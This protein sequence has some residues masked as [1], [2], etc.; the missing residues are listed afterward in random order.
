[1]D[2]SSEALEVMKK[3]KEEGITLL[4]DSDYEQIWKYVVRKFSM[5][6]YS[7]VKQ[8][9]RGWY[10]ATLFD[11]EIDHWIF[12]SWLNMVSLDRMEEARA[13]V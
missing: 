11:E 6:A 8:E 4:E 1:M 7:H 12:R 2:M 10:M 5:P 3:W 13:N 9:D